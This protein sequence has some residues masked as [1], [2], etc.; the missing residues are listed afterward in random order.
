MVTLQIVNL[1]VDPA[2][3][4]GDSLFEGTFN[5]MESIM[6]IVA[7]QI[8]NIEDCFPEHDEPDNPGKIPVEIVK[9]ITYFFSI[10]K[11]SQTLF[12]HSDCQIRPNSFRRFSSQHVSDIFSPPP[13]RAA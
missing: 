8:F 6:E 4:I 7:E 13:E 2:D 5:E 3:P 1:S 10:N 12:P 11:D 9:H